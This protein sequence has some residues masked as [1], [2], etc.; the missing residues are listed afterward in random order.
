MT[1]TPQA[2]KKSEQGVKDFQT[3]ADYRGMNMRTY[4]NIVSTDGFNVAVP[5]KIARRISHAFEARVLIQID[6]AFFPCQ[7]TVNRWMSE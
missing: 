4:I 1:T 3:D 6:G 7:D 5:A 2:T